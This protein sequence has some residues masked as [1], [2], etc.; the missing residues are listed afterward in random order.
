MRSKK[1]WARSTEKSNSRQPNPKFQTITNDRITNNQNI[2]FVI[3][4]LNLFGYCD[5]A[6][7]SSFI[8]KR[9]F[10]I[11]AFILF[12]FL[13]ARGAAYQLPDVKVA[14]VERNVPAEEVLASYKERLGEL[15]KK[16]DTIR[17]KEHMRDPKT[18]LALRERKA[19][20]EY[21]NLIDKIE[22]W[23]QIKELKDALCALHGINPPEEAVTESDGIAKDI[24]ETLYSLSQEWRVGGSALFTNFLI[25]IGAKEKGFCYHYAAALKKALSKRN[26]KYFEIRW[27]AAWEAT[28][29]ENNALIITAAGT[30]FEDGL[31]IDAWRTAGRPFWTPVKTDRFPWKEVLDVETKYEL[32]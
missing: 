29:R 26:W 9:L 20:K 27:G 8:M 10:P 14:D 12:A 4:Y 13:S 11:A 7:G 32:E 5:F 25:N 31:A 30:S 1:N 19:A 21:Y 2:L 18:R 23:R 15:E 22:F 17:L 6:A 24:I 28:F 3:G 16:A